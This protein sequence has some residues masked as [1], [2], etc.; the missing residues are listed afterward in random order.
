ML[1]EHQIPRIYPEIGWLFLCR[2]LVRESIKQRANAKVALKRNTHT[3][4]PTTSP[5]LHQTQATTPLLVLNT[6]P[7]TTWSYHKI[8]INTLQKVG[9]G[10]TTATLYAL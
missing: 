5:H 8:D 4:N 2:K 10:Y 1:V 7:S 6:D 9:H 3:A